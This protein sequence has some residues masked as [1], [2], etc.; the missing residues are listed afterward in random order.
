MVPPSSSSDHLDL[1]SLHSEPRTLCRYHTAHLQDSQKREID[2]DGKQHGGGQR[3][4]GVG[5]LLGTGAWGTRVKTCSWWRLAGALNVPS[6]PQACAA[7]W[8][9]YTRS[10]PQ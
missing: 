4:G 10:L 1:M 5:C 9:I 8:L 2:R 6:A 3:Q 7:R